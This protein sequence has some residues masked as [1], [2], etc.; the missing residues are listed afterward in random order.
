MTPQPGKQTLA[1]YLGFLLQVF[2]IH[3]T[4][5]EEGDYLIN[6]SLPPRVDKSLDRSVRSKAKGS[7]YLLFYSFSSIRYFLPLRFNITL[8]HTF[9]KFA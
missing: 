7:T 9:H 8:C 3:G 2:T 4:A 5:G 1:I 6:S